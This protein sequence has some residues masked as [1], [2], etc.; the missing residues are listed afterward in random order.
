MG[1]GLEVYRP[2]IK[3][4]RLDPSSIF[5]GLGEAKITVWR[6]V[7]IRFLAKATNDMISVIAQERLLGAA[8]GGV[9]SGVIVYEQ[10]KSIY[11]MI[12]QH[13]DK[14]PVAQSKVK[15]SVPRRRQIALLWNKAVDRTLGPL[16][17]SLSSRGW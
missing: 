5:P 10:R 3:T 4:L 16:I 1:R 14:L 9:F 15:D 13:E 2:I 6:S 17:T 11:Q 8:L 12:W 7:R